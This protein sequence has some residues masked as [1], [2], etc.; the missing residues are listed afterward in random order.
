LPD[1]DD[2]GRKHADTIGAAFAAV[3]VTHFVAPPSPSLDA[4]AIANI[5]PKDRIRHEAAAALA[6]ARS[7]ADVACKTVR[8][9]HV[10]KML[11]IHRKA[12]DASFKLIAPALQPLEAARA[13][14]AK[15]IEEL[16]R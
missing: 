2:A 13:K 10:D 11:D 14:N 9:I 4:A 7:C 8:E 6:L 15:V 3:G 12:H 16:P 1:N 5:E